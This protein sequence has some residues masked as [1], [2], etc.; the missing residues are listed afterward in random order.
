[1]SKKVRSLA[2]LN[3]AFEEGGE[4]SFITQ[5]RNVLIKD[6]ELKA[7]QSGVTTSFTIEDGVTMTIPV[8]SILSIV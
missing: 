8:D 4:G 1:M 7:G 2:E 6:F 3:K 5:N